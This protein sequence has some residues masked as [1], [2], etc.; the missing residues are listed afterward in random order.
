MRKG[1]VDRLALR[2]SGSRL[3]ITHASERALLLQLLSFED[4][5]NSIVQELKPNLLSLFL[6]ETANRFT[7]F[8]T[9]CSVWNEP[10]EDIRRSR[11]LMC[12]LSART[13]TLGLS[14]LGIQAP[15][16]M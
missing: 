11:L 1:N 16:K 8:Y 7:T 13:L 4:S 6:F 10:D 15:E 14:L 2:A 3:R 5:L 9:D 12:D